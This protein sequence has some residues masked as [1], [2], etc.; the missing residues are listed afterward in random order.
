MVDDVARTDFLFPEI[1]LKSLGLIPAIVFLLGLTA[2]TF[3]H[4][5][6]GID[7]IDHFF[8]RGFSRHGKN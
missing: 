8:L 2:A 6:F 3:C 5:R 1:A 4:N 7:G